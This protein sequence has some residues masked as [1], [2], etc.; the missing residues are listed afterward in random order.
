MYTWGVVGT[1]LIG[2]NFIETL[3]NTGRE[4][5]VAMCSHTHIKERFKDVVF[6]DTLDELL[7]DKDIT[8]LY[9]STYVNQHKELI[10]K[11]LAH[12]LHVIGEKPLFENAQDA[13]QAYTYA[14]CHNLLLG[15]ANTLF[16]MPLYQ[17]VKE[18]I[19]LGHIG[20]LKMIRAEFG[21][22]KEEER[23][24]AV[25]NPETGGGALYDIGIY[26]LSAVM[27]F[28]GDD[29]ELASCNIVHPFKVDEG[30]SILLKNKQDQ[31]ASINLSIRCKL[32]KRLLI[33]GDE[34]FIEI[35]NYPRADAY[36]MVDPAMKH[37]TYKAGN[38]EDAVLYEIQQVETMLDKFCYDETAM[39]FTCNV[40]RIMDQLRKEIT[41]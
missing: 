8:I 21:S 14:K 37:T 12:G 36:D 30:W 34:G 35:M 20:H 27:Q 6:Y 29:V 15:E 11:A 17:R 22:L 13:K 26:A 16:Y 41:L 3:I 28:L 38:S 32:D 39:S 23:A 33:A 40:M 5:R 31:L 25:M 2:E 7:E 1:D 10:K 9:I 4:C 18:E 24:S 19:R